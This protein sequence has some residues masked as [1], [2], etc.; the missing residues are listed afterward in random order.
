MA[1]K[2]NMIRKADIEPFLNHFDEIDT[3][4]AGFVPI[5]E[6]ANH[7]ANRTTSTVHAGG[8]YTTDNR[9][10]PIYAAV[11]LLSAITAFACLNFLWNCLYGYMLLASGLIDAALVVI[12]MTR[13]MTPANLCAVTAVTVL[14]ICSWLATT[15]LWMIWLIPHSSYTYYRFDQLAA[16]TFGFG[17]LQDGIFT[18]NSPSLYTLQEQDHIRVQSEFFSN[19]PAWPVILSIYTLSYIGAIAYH[20]RFLLLLLR[21][22]TTVPVLSSTATQVAV[23]SVS[24]TAESQP[25]QADLRT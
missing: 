19:S 6:L 10:E 5:T 22:S 14:A 24:A 25:P 3:A 7:V 4:R 17:F 11:P 20:V 21:C 12:T 15:T 16:A 9:N 18:R 23:T 13:E 2:L 1:I 8:R